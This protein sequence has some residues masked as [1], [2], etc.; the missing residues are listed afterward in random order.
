MKINNVWINQTS[1]GLAASVKDE[2][3]FTPVRTTTGT[4]PFTQAGNFDIIGDNIWVDVRDPE[5]HVIR[6]KGEYTLIRRVKAEH[7]AL[8]RGE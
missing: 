7:P 3:G 8:E 6:I 1:K 4:T 2:N 5:K